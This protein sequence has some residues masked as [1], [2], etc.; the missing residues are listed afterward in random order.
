MT[1]EP[2][3]LTVVR[4]FIIEHIG[5]KY[6]L[7]IVPSEDNTARWGAFGYH[8][9]IS[10]LPGWDSS[11]VGRRNNVGDRYGYNYSAALDVGVWGGSRRWLAWLISECRAGHYL[12]L[13]GVIGSLDGKKQT[14]W[15]VDNGWRG[16]RYTAGF[17]DHT[18]HTHLEWWRDS[19]H[20]S[21]AG[22]LADWPGWHPPKPSPQPSESHA[23][24]RSGPIS[25]TGHPPPLSV[26]VGP[27]GAVVG[28]GLAALAWILHRRM[29]NED[30]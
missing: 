10:E 17:G 25:P 8:Y 13:H 11:V 21:Q 9:G 5:R 16:E 23:K 12:D 6:Y 19:V 20:R 4:D 26:P 15:S 14:Y 7:G 3:G 24:P 2:D 18:A 1:R 22:V 27:G 28:L 29:S 30:T